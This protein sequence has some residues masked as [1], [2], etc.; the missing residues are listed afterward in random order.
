MVGRL[1][2]KVCIITGSGGAIG[3]ASA[4]LFAR[5]GAQVVGCD[6]SA[7]A[8]AATVEAV[9]AN[10]GTMTSLHPC[11]IT[12]AD[13]CQ[14]LVDFAVGE[15]GRLDIL[16]NNAGKLYYA[17]LDDAP[18]TDFWY[19]TIDQELNLTFLMTRAAWPQLTARGGAIV[20]MASTAG[21]IA[22]EVLGGLA[23]CA[24]KGGVLAMTRQLAM[25]G[26]KHGVRANSI[27]P[28][29]IKTPGNEARFAD[30]VWA[31]PMLQKIMRGSPGQP[32]EIAA[33]AL[34]LASDESAFVNGAD[35]IA[36]GGMTA[37]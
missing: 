2:G 7:E 6:I 37:W 27:S 32:A 34:F 30:P 10:G 35:I 12:K 24:A 23:H 16:F 8:G 17:W 26:R 13:Q 28:G 4:L 14:A 29:V 25:E 22:F 5:E 15:F 31:A 18:S 19:Q 20:N 3:R 1:E 33:V 36:D 11:D 21:W 9:R